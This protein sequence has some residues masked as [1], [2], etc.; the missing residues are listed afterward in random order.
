MKKHEIEIAI[1]IFILDRLFGVEDIPKS[2][3]KITSR[4]VFDDKWRVN[5]FMKGK[6]TVVIPYSYLVEFSIE[7]GIISSTPDIIRN[8]DTE[9]DEPQRNNF[10]GAF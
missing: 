5:V 1:R 9:L 3:Y 4:N 8:K 7:E 6:T 10:Q 2:V